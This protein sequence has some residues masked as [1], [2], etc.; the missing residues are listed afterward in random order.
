MFPMKK[1]PRTTST[2]TDSIA[3]KILFT[4][5]HGRLAAFFILVAVMVAT[6]AVSTTFSANSPGSSSLG[7]PDSSLRDRAPG[8]GS[9]GGTPVKASGSVLESK[10]F[11]TVS[12][13]TEQAA[14]T[15]TTDKASYEHDETITF[16]G[17][18]WSPGEVVTIVLRQE[19]SDAEGATLQATADESGSFTVTGSLPEPQATKTISGQASRSSAPVANMAAAEVGAVYTATATGSIS[20]AIAQAQIKEGPQGDGDEDDP[21]LPAFMAGKIDKAD[22]LRRRAEHISKLRGIHPGRPVDPGARGRAIREMNRQEGRPDNAASAI[23]PTNT[24][25]VT[26][27]AFD[28]TQVTASATSSSSIW[29]AIGPYPLPNGQTFNTNNVA[30]S[31]RTVAIAIHPTN[32]NIAY[33]GAAQGGVYR[34]FDGGA[35]WTPIF[36]NAQTLAIGSI[37]I[38]PSQPSTI[39]VGTGEGNFG[40]DTFAGVGV[41]RIDNADGPN[42]TLTG[43]LNKDAGGNDVLSGWATGKI[44]VHPTNP[45][46]IFI[47]TTTG[48]AGQNCIPVNDTSA[49]STRPRG[50]FRSTNA[51]QANPTFTKLTIA[52]V[53]NSGNRSVSDIEFE[54]GNPNTLLTTVFGGGASGNDAG[55][56]RTTNA[57]DA[58]PTFTRTLAVGDTTT[59]YRTELAINKVG[60]QV[61]VFAATSEAN[62]TLKRSTNGGVSWSAALGGTGFCGGQCTYDMPIAVDPNNA[63]LVYLGGPGDS[64]SAHILTKVTNALATPTFTASQTGLHA[65]EHAIEIDPNNTNIIWTGNDGGIFKSTNAASTWTS[66][67]NTGYSATQFVSLALHPTDANFTIGGTQDNGTE[68]QGPCGTTTGNNWSQAD[69][70]DGGFALIDQSAT[71]LT[72]VNMYHTY[73]NQ[74]STLIGYAY[75]TNAANAKFTSSPISNSWSFIGTGGAA[76]CTSG[77]GYAC[78]E[79]VEFYMPMALGPGS[80]NPIYSGTDRLHRSPSPGSSN[81][82]VSQVFVSGV[83]ITAVGISQQNDSVRI[84]GLENGKVFRTMTAQTTGWPDVSGTI[85]SGTAN[86]ISRAVIDPNNQNTAYVTISNYFGNSTPHIYKTTNLNAT[87]PTWTGIGNTIPDIPINAFAVDPADSNKLYA[88]TDIGVYRSTDGGATWEP[89]SNGL[90][91]VAVFDMAIQ[92]PNRILR[93]ATHGRGMWEISLNA[94]VNPGTL[95][96]TVTDSATSA[97]INGAT[98]KAGAN[99]TTTNAS[100]FYV[101]GEIA[102][103]SYSVTAS[104]PGYNTS[105]PTSATV[106]SDN[107]TTQNFALTPAP[108][109]GC[110]TDTSQAD[111]QAGTGSNVDLTGSPGN[112]KLASGAGALDQQNTSVGSSGDAI[113]TT[114]W[115][116]QTFIP[117]VTG[118]LT[119]VDADLF[120]SA[121]SGTNPDVTI[122]IRT[123]SGGLPTSTVLASTTITGFSAGSGTFYSATFSSPATLTTGTTYAIVARLTTARA[124]GTYAWLRANNNQY[125]SGTQLISTASGSSW[126][127]Q[128]RDLGFKTY[129]STGFVTSGDLTSSV[130]DSNPATGNAPNWTT[131]SWT[132]A[133]PTNT[134]VKFQAAS[135]NSASGP[136]SFVGPDGTAA[137][138]FTTSGA[139]LSQFSGK[140]Y[141][142]YKA[143]LSTTS[144]SV[145]PT[146]NDVTVCFVNGALPS[147]TTTVNSASG[148]Y[149]GTTALTATLTSSSSPLSGKLITFT[150]NGSGVGSAVTNG[151]GVATLSNASLSGINAGSYPN[152]V[153]ASFASD[154]SYAGSSGSNS[155]TVGKVTPT[156]T[157]SNP[158]SIVYG[159]ALGGTQLNATASVP[160]S[161]VYTPASG[162]VLGA[163]NGQNLHADFTPTDTTNYNTASKDVSISVTKVTLTVT[164]DNQS[165]AYGDPNPAL[166]YTMTGFVNGD[167]QAG[168]TTGQ[169][170]VTT[171]ANN[172]SA[173][174]SYTITTAIGTLT[175]ANYSFSFVNATLTITK[176]NQTIT[177]GALADKTF[178]DADFAVSAN[179]SSGLPVSF[180]ASGNC[181]VSGSNVHI[182]GAGSCTIT[183]SQGGNA[184]YN[185][186]AN[187]PQ[188][189]TINKAGSTTT[190]TVGNAT[191]DSQSHGGSATVTGAGGLNQSLTV[192][193]AG[194]NGTTY[195]PST[196]APT[197]AG[198]YT[199]S[200]TFDGDANHDGSSDSEEF[201]IA[202]ATATLSLSDLSQTYTGAPLAA[203]ATTSPNGLSG[204][205]VT[206]DGSAT[207]PTGAGSYAV[208][209]TLNNQNYEADNATGTLTISKAAPV[210]SA[211]G[212]I[213]TYSGTACAGSG[214]A[215]GVDGNDLGAVTLVY[216]PGG[217][218]PINAG[219]Y[220][221]VASIAET[222]NHT[223]GSSAPA[224]ITINKAAPTISVSVPS[225][226]VTYDG[227]THPASGFAYGVGGTGDV[228]SP[229]VTFTYNGAADEPVN[230]DT[231]AVMASFGGNDNYLSATNNSAVIVIS[232]AAATVSVNGGTFTYDGAAH[233]ATGFAYGI[234]GVSDTLTPAVTFTYNGD[235]ETPVNA[236][237]YNVVASFAGNA[238]YNPA[239]NTTTIVI[240]KATPTITWSNPADIIYGTA[241]GGTQLNAT[242]SVPGSFVYTPAAGTVLGAGNGQNLH[243]DFTP[244]DT[245]NYNTASKDVSI[246]VL[247][248]SQAITFGALANKTYGDAPFIVSATGGASGNPVTFS[249]TGNCTSGG[250]NGSTITITGAGNCT[251]TAA[252]VGNSNYNAAPDVARSFQIAKAAATI[253][254]SNLYYLYDGTP[255]SATAT[256]A[257][258]GLSGVTIN[259]TGVTL[260]YNSTTPPSAAGTYTATASLTN[261][262]YA[263]TN[264][265]ATFVINAAPTVTITGPASGAIYTKGSTVSFT[266]TFTDNPGTH[267]ATWTFQSGTQ[268]ITQPATVNETTGA[269]SASYTFAATGV[270]MVKLTVS[271]NFGVVG[272]ATTVNGNTLAPAFIAVYD[273]SST[274][275]SVSTTT[276]SPLFSS[277]AGWYPANPTLTGT[278]TTGF[279]ASYASATATA[280]TGQAVFNFAAAG[281]SLT[282]Q[283]YQW[284][285]VTKPYV[286][287]RGSGTVNNVSGYEF[288]IAAVDGQL[289]GGG[290]T[291]KFR[292]RIWRKSDGVV[293]YDNMPG[294]ALSAVAT[295]VTSNGDI[296]I[297]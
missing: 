42:P 256:T 51:T 28:G 20:G 131:L 12:S 84:V 139:S 153:G 265:T 36:D 48:Y 160:G 100:G 17:T 127:A 185:A 164:A 258:S 151:S 221:V 19:S 285:V 296:A 107:T 70:G 142:K 4:K 275:G 241:L 217:T 183:A 7:T 278:A 165:R 95:Q 227:Q 11:N 60:S 237:T 54:P 15:L 229:A 230:A 190:V 283:S 134:A 156:I 154:G 152:G 97:P 32:S 203:T 250:T 61:N 44:V 59:L 128:S 200:A 74:T 86:Y 280:P 267:T 93:I 228:L 206:Y 186:A 2:P 111:F 40:C 162:T 291:D 270:Y 9:S 264:A 92:N 179:A 22:Y 118:Q 106:T 6:V 218:A 235:T 202:K 163:G 172:T 271:D 184:N 125:G 1:A 123:T 23:D 272:Q 34:T 14:P 222:A 55:V 294:G 13:Q 276:K 101:F 247:K 76:S 215:T 83:P 197:N 109:S 240:N 189:F 290:G 167:T 242:A 259:Y 238:N 137:T 30:V 143:Y 94:P 177:F 145:T 289:T 214:S 219:S 72:S 18:N 188:T 5:R 116:A 24:S 223:A 204:V 39:Y 75:V 245:T 288:L 102:P 277:L 281:L 201:T 38:A 239:S 130:K 252:Q 108:T 191:F 193:Y 126:T 129:M 96:G 244:T 120:C 262:N 88:G 220:T 257:P 180:A 146:L 207:A 132:A 224:S 181:T 133:T 112:V 273:P 213:C 144:G 175:S 211:T 249:A 274:G 105:P 71:S 81:A 279:N 140:R 236:T 253:T 66:L 47:G 199:A 90:P 56:Y 25:P 243:A 212:N 45:D 87:T 89:F 99:T 98:V 254:L 63:N 176:A 82:T 192:T 57:L 103:G 284:M 251:V 8:R 231:Y 266:G 293:I 79:A 124:T 195:G 115:E 282:S 31:G 171:T 119:Q 209:A 141:L 37:A 208:I 67:N 29:T 194:R 159:T 136:F 226:P 50:L 21:D 216:T 91:R 77:G 122:D 69:Y 196:T 157:W 68:C 169:P 178:G 149:G 161:F 41:Y 173:P 148:T 27:G 104:A 121:C 117:G 64:G 268:T 65:D 269:V 53:L 49:T 138:F 80:P 114:T 233:P 182:T 260:S 46:I 248:A 26:T 292:I 33:A 155:L 174:G 210:M 286:W 78:T 158:A 73:Y 263:A 147:T 297:K 85:P 225:G 234:N 205:T 170:S 58:S 255:K 287:L 198:D 246:N 62:G 3:R 43:P 113:T 110:L 295:I 232:K 150:L 135:S 10:L 261:D 16:T 52:G 35:T 166:T 168:A 187:V